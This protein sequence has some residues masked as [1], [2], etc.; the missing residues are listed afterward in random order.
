MK[1]WSREAGEVV[2]KATDLRVGQSGCYFYT[3]CGYIA[4]TYGGQYTCAA[5]AQAAYLPD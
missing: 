4:H 1:F 5:C 3:V 2:M